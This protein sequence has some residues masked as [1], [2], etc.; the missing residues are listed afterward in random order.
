MARFYN[1]DADGAPTPAPHCSFELVLRGVQAGSAE[2]VAAAAEG[3]RS[4]GFVNYYGLQRF[5]TGAVPTHRCTR[6]VGLLMPAGG[7]QAAVWGQR[8]AC[9]HVL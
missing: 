1:F 2:A 4:S 5:G 3:L 6:N 7:L 9:C 8:W